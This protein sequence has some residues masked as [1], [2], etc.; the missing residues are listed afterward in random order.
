[1]AKKEHQEFAS[2]IDLIDVLPPG[3]YEAV[4]TPETATRPMPSGVSGDWIVRFEPR[5]LDD[6]RAIGGPTPRTNA[7][8]RPCGASRR[9]TWA[10]TARCCSPS[11]R[12]PSTS[13]AP[14]GCSKLNHAELPYEV[15]SQRNPL[16]QQVAQLAE[17]V[18][19]QRQP[20]SADNPLLQWQ[21]A[22]SQAI[23]AA[24]DGYRDLRDASIEKIFLSVYGSPVL[25]AMLGLAGT[26]EPPR[27]SPGIEPARAA[28]I[29]QRIGE[30]KARLAEG[31]AARSRD[32][33]AGVHRH[34]RRRRRRAGLQR[35]APDPHREPGP[36][37][38]GLQAGAARAVLQPAARPR[39]GAGRHPED[40]AGR[41]GQ[42]TRILEAIRR[43]VG[44]AGQPS[45]EKAQRLAQIE[46]ICAGATPVARR[47]TV[48]RKAARAAPT[49]RKK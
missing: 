2:N 28:L 43:T 18:R 38:A 15:F 9:S 27:Q 45:G 48:P 41:R 37:A 46:Q 16:M 22:M 4:L 36:D 33:R 23:V 24:L 47:K 7:A 30:L 29:K 40:A 6:M 19:E 17:Q 5:T 49:P 12:R 13:R 35:T 25:Q 11:S 42:R 3:L 1:M 39:G 32:P 44:A 26:T 8:L 21:E 34:G 31:G 10:C 20:V 14:T